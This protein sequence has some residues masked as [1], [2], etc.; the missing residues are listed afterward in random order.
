MEKK[1]HKFVGQGRAVGLRVF[2]MNNISL[3]FCKH[4]VMTPY[5]ND[6]YKRK[7]AEGLQE[8]YPQSQNPSI[9]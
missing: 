1:E 2:S 7:V 8:R 9:W 6:S 4:G 5:S 3:H